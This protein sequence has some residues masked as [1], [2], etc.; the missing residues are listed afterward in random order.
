MVTKKSFF[1]SAALMFLSVIGAPAGNAHTSQCYTLES[2][3]GSYTIIG[4][5]GNDLALALTRAKLDGE[6]NFS[7]TFVINEPTPGSTTGERTIVTGSQEGTYIVNCDGTGVITRLVKTTTGITE[8]V[9]SDFVI[10][11]A[12]HGQSGVPVATALVDAQRTPSGI[13]PGGVF[14]TRN[15]TRLPD[16]E[17]D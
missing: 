6:G 16:P 11:R 2:L 13:V 4:H 7:A 10:T 9:V 8:T 15:Y 3:K 5:Y 12:V 14:L 1:V 17:D